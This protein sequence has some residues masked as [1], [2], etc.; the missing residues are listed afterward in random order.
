MI[1]QS[2]LFLLLW[3]LSCTTGPAPSPDW[4]NSNPSSRTAWYGVGI[5]NLSQEDYRQIANTKARDEIASQI[6]VHIESSLKTVTTEVNYEVEAFA[7]SI[8]QSRVNM[9][10]EDVAITKT[11]S[12][13]EHYYVLAT[14]LHSDYY[15]LIELRKQKA[16]STAVDFLESAEENLTAESFNYLSRALE[17]IQPF[18]DYPLQ[19]EYPSESGNKVNL[20]SKI[21]ILA[22]DFN[23]RVS[24][25]CSESEISTTIGI[26]DEHQ[27]Q[28]SCM[29]KRTQK[30]IPGFPLQAAMNGNSITTS[31]I[32]DEKGNA[33]FHLFKVKD[34]TPVQYFSIKIAP[35][36][37]GGKI[38]ITNPATISIKVNA[39]AP[40]IFMD[41]T[42]KSLDKSVSNP[43]VMPAFKEFF[44]ATYGATFTDKKA[45]SDYIVTGSV[46]T[47]AKSSV[48]NEYD[49][50]VVYADGT[51][52]ITETAT[53]K[54]IYSKSVTNVKGVDFTSLEGAGRHA[55][56][57]MVEKLEAESFQEIIDGLDGNRR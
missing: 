56:K 36:G 33:T 31:A 49:L 35:P 1:K 10:L 9:T 46:K 50:Y 34:R 40:T 47:V 11:Y 44:V 23:N 43:L 14:L 48:P 42:E 25:T 39:N 22:G 38:D 12:D 37:I 18:M 52:S 17:E 55:L 54:E 32:T 27:F 41:I 26:R 45:S 53:N 15:R 7:E 30:P 21:H 57:K 20:F 51:L 2:S 24:L 19:V 8:I 29:D 16:I 4:V 13:G 6:S 28:V 5:S 3:M